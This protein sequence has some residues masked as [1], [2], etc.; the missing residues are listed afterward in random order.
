MPRVETRMRSCNLANEASEPKF[1]FD[2]KKLGSGQ[3]MAAGYGPLIQIL[4]DTKKYKEC[5][6]LISSD[7]VDKL[8]SL[9]HAQYEL[10]HWP[11][12]EYILKCFFP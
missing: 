5:E 9:L 1:L 12:K 11:Q 4:F 8:Q 6:I 10:Y 2:S 7:R 3:K